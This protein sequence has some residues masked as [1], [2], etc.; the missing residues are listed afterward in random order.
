MPSST[1]SRNR[2]IWSASKQGRTGG[3]HACTAHTHDGTQPYISSHPA[4]T[5]R[6]KTGM[7]LGGS[8]GARWRYRTG[9]CGY[10]RPCAHQYVGKSQSCMVENGR[11]IPH[12]Y[13][14]RRAVCVCIVRVRRLVMPV[15]IVGMVTTSDED[16][17]EAALLA[18]HCDAGHRPPHLLLRQPTATS[19]LACIAP[20]CT[21]ENLL[22][23]HCV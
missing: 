4:V 14:T 7:Q 17:L 3:G 12:A 5:A 23:G 21:P 2:A 19:R 6:G 10:N 15:R 1:I 22:H 20:T 11:L 9:A 18:I 13:R 16:V 8:A